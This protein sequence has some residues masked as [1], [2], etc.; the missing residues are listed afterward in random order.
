VSPKGAVIVNAVLLELVK[1]AVSVELV[2][3]T[4]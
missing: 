2:V 4:A 3:P 1:V